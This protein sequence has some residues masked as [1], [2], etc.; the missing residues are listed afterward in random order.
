[1]AQAAQAQQDA[2]HRGY[3]P[4]AVVHRPYEQPP[5]AQPPS[6]APTTPSSATSQPESVPNQAEVEQATVL[7]QLIQ[8]TDAQLATLPPDQRQA[9]IM[10][11]EQ[12]SRQMP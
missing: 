7:L 9:V 5:A 6:Y 3:P 11:R 12:L 4:A 2:Y 1:M 8:M 10:L